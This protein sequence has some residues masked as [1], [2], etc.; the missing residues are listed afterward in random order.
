MGIYIKFWH[1][2]RC[3]LSK[4]GYVTSPKKQISKKFYFFLI[5]HLILGKAAKLLVVKLSTSEVVKQKPHGGWK[6]PPTQVLLGLKSESFLRFP[7]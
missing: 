5:L 2:L 7:V 6:T 1:L 4:Y 3:P